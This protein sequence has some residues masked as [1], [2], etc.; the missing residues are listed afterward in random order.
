[1]ADNEAMERAKKLVAEDKKVADHSKQV[2]QER[3]TGK[4]TPTQ[5]END[6]AAHGATFEHHEDDGS[7]LDPFINQP[8]E[9]SQ[10][11]AQAT[12]RPAGYQTR[13]TT[14]ARSSSSE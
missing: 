9:S 4:P 1:M 12:G 11:H 10:K 13:H 3:A 14:A 7:P 8:G 2:F 5:E 6:L